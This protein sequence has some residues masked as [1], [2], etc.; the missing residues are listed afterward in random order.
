MD[1][2]LA[3]SGQQD[4]WV[5]RRAAGGGSFKFSNLDPIHQLS[6]RVPL[7]GGSFLLWNQLLVHGSCAN[8]SENFRIAQF[9]TGFRA[10]EMT[11]GRSWA[12]ARAVRRLCGALPRQ[13]LAPHV[14][15]EAEEADEPRPEPEREL[16]ARD[17][18]SW[19]CEVVLQSPGEPEAVLQAFEDFHVQCRP[20]LQVGPVK[21]RHLD[22]AV[23]R[24]RPRRC[25]ELGSFLG[26][27]AVRI[28][29]LL[30]DG[31]FLYTIEQDADNAARTAAT[32]EHA[33]LT[34]KATALCGTLQTLQCQLEG[35]FELI[36]L[37]HS[38][39]LYLDEIQHL[40]ALG[41][42]ED[43]TTVVADNI[44]GCNR[45]DCRR[46]SCGCAYARYV[47]SSGR[48]VS[49]F[50][51]GS[52]DGIEVSV[53]Q[54]Q[55]AN[56]RCRWRPPPSTSEDSCVGPYVVDL[57]V[58][59]SACS[60]SATNELMVPRL[61]VLLKEYVRHRQLSLLEVQTFVDFM[62]AGAF[63]CAFYRFCEFNVRKDDAD[64]QAKDS[65]LLMAKRAELL[66]DG[67]VREAVTAAL[68][69]VCG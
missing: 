67:S 25:L 13:K 23:R 58:C 31:A 33:G 2:N 4:N 10:G 53:A 15:G 60:F 37:D 26:Y 40:E 66:L 14:F 68:K 51:W 36:F 6:R 54:G 57:A 39:A 61:L 3:Q 32:L 8:R 69:E 56:P 42:I 9:I 48:Y 29:R 41:F 27:S 28:A 1:Q 46:V 7:R 50:F 35:P 18:Q 20:L 34:G 12:R 49:E 21:G 17:R 16:G 22:A 55:P 47:R 24:R 65:Y 59:A 64:A 5:L 11:P 62:A 63:A 43:G 52:R 19:A 38:K 30:D 45:G 44:G